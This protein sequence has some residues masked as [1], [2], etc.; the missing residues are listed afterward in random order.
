LTDH[1][2]LVELDWFDEEFNYYVNSKRYNLMCTQD[3]YWIPQGKSEL[4]AVDDMDLIHV[5]NLISWL[6][7]NYYLY[8]DRYHDH[9]LTLIPLEQSPLYIRLKVRYM[10]L[11]GN[12][13]VMDVQ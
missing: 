1:G 7:R 2:S 3:T 6:E 8:A 5:Y 4:I 13:T 10:E 11:M 12:F 9:L